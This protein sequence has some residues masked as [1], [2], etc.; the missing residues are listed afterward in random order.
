MDG[1]LLDDNHEIPDELWPLVDVMHE[2][3]IYFAPASGRQYFTLAN[4]FDQHFE[5]MLF[6]SENGTNVV[7]DGQTVDS[8]PL[9]REVVA[10]V[11]GRVR[12]FAAD[13]MDVGLIL[14]GTQAAYHERSDADFL[15]ATK[16][17]YD[18]LELVD[19]LLEVQDTALKVGVWVSTNAERDIVPHLGDLTTRCEVVISAEHWVDVMARGADKGVAVRHMQDKLGITAD[20]TMVFGDFHNDLGMLSQAHYSYAM[21]NAHPE[22]QA[23]ARF[24]A[25]ANTELGVIQVLR[26]ALGL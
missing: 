16:R 18:R 11:V 19:D 12:K 8:S 23:A 24:R 1:T 3:G 20:Q 25:P 10:D 14:A 17:Y 5:G 15:A 13:G 21:A 26:S 6:I 9:E 4:M 7:Q 2:R 22:V